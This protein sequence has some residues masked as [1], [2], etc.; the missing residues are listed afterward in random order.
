MT[1]CLV[2]RLSTRSGGDADVDADSGGHCD[3]SS[4][5]SD[6]NTP[7]QVSDTVSRREIT[8][9]TEIHEFTEHTE[10]TERMERLVRQSLRRA[11]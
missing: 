8:E 7:S 5:A 9:V 4:A 1:D 6:A 2:D 3:C 10:H 11:G